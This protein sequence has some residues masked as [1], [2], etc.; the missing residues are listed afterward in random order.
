[1][2]FSGLDYCLCGRCGNLKGHVPRPYRAQRH[3]PGNSKTVMCPLVAS[4]RHVLLKN[5]V[6]SFC[7]SGNALQRG[8]ISAAGVC[9]AGPLLPAWS[10]LEMG[11]WRLARG[12]GAG[13]ALR[14]VLSSL[15]S[16]ASSSLWHFVLLR[17]E[18]AFFHPPHPLQIPK[19]PLFPAISF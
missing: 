7:F 14:E 12:F 13:R 2:A 6:C 3:G 8:Q 16:K 17:A 15:L 18:P 4:R 5:D 9:S 11:V 1:M 10:F 19:L